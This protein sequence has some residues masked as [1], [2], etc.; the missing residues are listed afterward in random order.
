MKLI[1]VITRRC[2]FKKKSLNVPGTAFG[3]WQELREKAEKD[4]IL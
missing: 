1:V 4:N 3:N 2:F